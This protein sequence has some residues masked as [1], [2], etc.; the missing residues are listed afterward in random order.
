MARIFISHSSANNAE[1]LAVADWLGRQGWNDVFLDID[2][3]RG[4]VAGQRWQNALKS[5]AARCEVVVFLLSPAWANSRWCLAEFLLAKQMNK[6]IMGVL[7][8]S[9]D[10]AALPVEM[11]AEYQL[12][13][14]KAPGETEAIA[15]EVETRPVTVEFSAEGLKRLRHGLQ[16]SGIDA[17]F[18]HWPP[19]D[20]PN[21]SPYPGL[22]PLDTGD[23]GIFFGRE[24]QIIT[25]LDQLRHLRDAAPPR[26][27]VIL[28]ASGSGKSSFMR[29]GLLPRLE[30]DDRHFTV[31]PP[32]R[33]DRGALYG[34]TGLA[35][36]LYDAFAGAGQPKNRVTLRR[37][38]EDAVSDAGTDSGAEG[39]APVAALLAELAVLHGHDLDAGEDAVTARHAIV[40][41]IDQGEALFAAEGRAEATA[42]LAL[43]RNLLNRESPALA[44]I[45]TIRSD[46]Y[47]RLQTED[48]LE[49]IRPQI[50][51][52]PPMPVGAYGEV[53]RGPAARLTQTGRKLKLDDALVDTLLRD[54]EAG[55]GKDALPL[56][57]FTLERLFSDYGEDGDLTLAEYQDLGGIRGAINAAVERALKRADGNPAIPA[58][59]DARQVLLRRGLIPWLAGIDPDSGSPRRRVARLSEIPAEA[60][61]LM[62][63]LVEER[64]LATDV[65]PDTKETTIEPAHEALLRQWGRLGGWLEED[66]RELTAIEGV[67]R[68]ARDWAAN[69]KDPQWLAHVAGRLEDAEAAARRADLK[70]LLQPTDLAY[71]YAAREAEDRRARAELL[72]LRRQRR[73][74][75]VAGAV[76]AVAAVISGVLW[77]QADAARKAE[78][79]ALIAEQAARAEETAQ[80]IRAEAS[81]KLARSRL[82]LAE[83]KVESA[84]SLALDGLELDPSPQARSAAL[85]ALMEISPNLTALVRGAGANA[86]ALGWS[87]SD[88][89]VAAQG[90]TLRHFAPDGA[91]TGD[92]DILVGANPEPAWL[93]DPVFVTGLPG[94]ATAAV[95][96]SGEILVA[97]ANG[98]I[99]SVAAPTGGEPVYAGPHRIAATPD[100]AVIAFARTDRTVVV[101]RC[102]LERSRP[103]CR[104]Q[105]FETLEP[106]AIALTRDGKHLAVAAPDAS[107]AIHDVASGE[108]LVTGS[109]VQADPIALDFS[110]DGALIAAGSRDGNV[111]ILRT[112]ELGPALEAGLASIQLVSKGPV[113]TLRWAPD[114]K[115]LALTCDEQDIC[116]F[117]MGEIDERALDAPRWKLIGH[118]G[119]IAGLVWS[120]DGTAL[121]S[122]G[123]DAD[124]RL[125]SA[126][127]D[128][129]LRHDL[130]P[131]AME[132]LLA[133]AADPASGRIVTGNASGALHLWPDTISQNAPR[134]IDS[135]GEYEPISSVAFA[136]NG[137]VAAIHERMGLAS[138]NIDGGGAPL[139]LLPIAGERVARTAFV[140]DGIIA[141]VPSDGNSVV[142]YDPK[143]ET[144][145]ILDGPSGQG[146]PFGVTGH[147]DA[148]RLF[149]SQTDG[150]LMEW[151]LD[152][153][154]PRVIAD[155]AASDPD[156]LGGGSLSVSPD[157]R[158]LVAS[159]TP[160]FVIVHD[161]AGTAPPV[162]LALDTGDRDVKT[163]AFSP[164]GALLAALLSNGKL[165]I[166]RWSDGSA[167]RF[168]VTQAVPERSIAGQSASRRRAAS[169]LAWAGT[170]TLA[171]A[172]AAGRVQI[173][174]LDEVAWIARAKGLS[175]SD[176]AT[177]DDTGGT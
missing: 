81:E 99:T 11:T 172:T 78:A 113:V 73:W 79:Q 33:P 9:T 4:L 37:A 45:F 166:W 44:A 60:R 176:D 13:D 46:S 54:I 169:W 84:V 110:P 20:E 29:A 146:E 106:A 41:P 66:L 48:A 144:R 163:V 92:M 25:G 24:A 107:L 8:D 141:A 35:A 140:G 158:W 111:T 75:M 90:G 67:R 150:S 125:W 15:V 119:A 98:T 12:V 168:A 72:A 26:M 171:I 136:S 56:L 100:G 94:G 10:I 83:G 116:I 63:L 74:A 127:E 152:G 68:A 114:G 147:P 145:R 14:L 36:S 95:L 162:R 32:V 160:S 103:A 164:D 130:A 139:P 102:A 104:D 161:L 174:S 31:L 134:R 126:A 159:N 170:K 80:R 135:S 173:L 105:V 151:P 34:E 128:T 117:D 101:R 19:E 69:A 112:A 52:L 21:R 157:G 88:I 43:L 59:H 124:L 6:R 97:G 58:D 96:A 55:G 30:R 149:T 77:M 23:A 142:L 129:A 148:R 22:R 156:A 40:L 167:E 70:D 121:A 82:A 5:A 28:G 153:G 93:S 85:T 118:A 53:I 39:V 38:I 131:V 18:F 86:F 62:E 87:G 57:A 71:L 109:S 165:Y 123:I 122:I 120:P 138:G 64:L 50:L 175:V 91:S 42:F 89:S 137:D 132:E 7:V 108:R 1:A 27:M 65:D 2:P 51:S 154:A 17:Q 3:Q 47:E 61:P 76:F 177:G 133:V 49:D 115:T 143:A 155:P 16:I